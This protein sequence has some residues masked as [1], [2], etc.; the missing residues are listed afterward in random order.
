MFWI[1]RS[2]ILVVVIGGMA[3][4]FAYLSKVLPST[5]LEAVLSIRSVFKLLKWARSLANKLNALI[6]L[7]EN[8]S[9]SILMNNNFSSIVGGPTFGTFTLGERITSG[10]HFRFKGSE[11]KFDWLEMIPFE[12]FLFPFV[13]VEGAFGALLPGV[14]V[15]TWLYVGRIRIGSHQV[16]LSNLLAFDLKCSALNVNINR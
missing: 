10:L 5:I 6:W 11:L 8:A 13:G 4:G 9:L 7:V 15:C 16:Q 14:A 1:L 2:K 12:G 3:I